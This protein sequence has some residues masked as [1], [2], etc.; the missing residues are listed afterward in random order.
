[1]NVVVTLADG[2]ETKLWG[3][4]GDPALTPLKKGNAVQ[5]VKNAKGTGYSL[6]DTSPGTPAA[7]SAPAPEP[8]YSPRQRE[9]WKP[10][11]DEE[12]K[13][14]AAKIDQE[15][16]LMKYCLK[17]VKKEF[18]DSGLVENE[19]SVCSLASVLFSHWKGEKLVN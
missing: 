5:L 1:I 7:P 4:P 16:D 6:L 10:W 12:K 2:E 19:A 9:T 8:E 11:T 3:D 13:Q 18:F 14:L 15:A 17:I